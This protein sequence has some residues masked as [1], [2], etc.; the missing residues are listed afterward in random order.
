[1][2]G[3]V[4]CIVVFDVSFVCTFSCCHLYVSRIVVFDVS[5]VCTFSCGRVYVLSVVFCILSC[6]NH[7]HTL[8]LSFSLFVEGPE[9]AAAGGLERG[10]LVVN[11]DVQFPVLNYQGLSL[12]SRC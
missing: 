6:L 2:C 7:T 1:M 11:L 9:A 10:F 12:Y 4:S 8:F 5:F 3:L